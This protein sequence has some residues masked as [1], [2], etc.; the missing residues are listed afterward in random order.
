MSR[1]TKKLLV[2][3]TDSEHAK[4]KLESYRRGISM[5]SILR[6]VIEKMPDPNQ[7]KK[8]DIYARVPEY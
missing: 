6:E 4:L 5:S 8:E 3:L 1:K 2:Y 7:K